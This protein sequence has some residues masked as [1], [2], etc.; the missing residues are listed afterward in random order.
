MDTYFEHVL[1][2]PIFCR[3]DIIAPMKTEWNAMNKNIEKMC[4]FAVYILFCN[5]NTEQK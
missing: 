1:L 5:K 3:Q 2:E 4:T